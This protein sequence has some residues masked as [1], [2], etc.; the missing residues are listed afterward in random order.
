MYILLGHQ[1]VNRLSFNL[2]EKT[3]ALADA[4]SKYD[5][6]LQEK[7]QSNSLCG[8]MV[9]DPP[10]LK[11][12]GLLEKNEAMAG[13]I[14]SLKES[15]QSQED[16]LTKNSEALDKKPIYVLGCFFNLKVLSNCNKH[17][18]ILSNAV[19]AFFVVVCIEGEKNN[20]QKTDIFF[21][22]K[23]WNTVEFEGVDVILK[24]LEELVKM[25]QMESDKT[26]TTPPPTIDDENSPQLENKVSI[27]EKKHNL[28]PF[29]P[30]TVCYLVMLQ[31]FKS[32][33]N[34]IHFFCGCMKEN[35]QIEELSNEETQTNNQI[36]TEEHNQAVK[37]HY[38]NETK[39]VIQLNYKTDDIIA[40][41]VK[42]ETFEEPLT[43]SKEE[44]RP[45]HKCDPVMHELIAFPSPL[46]PAHSTE[47]NKSE[48]PNVE[49][50]ILPPESAY[51]PE[52]ETLPKKRSLS[53][54]ETTEI[55][56]P[57]PHSENDHSTPHSKRRK[58]L[59]SD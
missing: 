45:V 44:T 35:E 10:F 37:N 20:T 47:E 17:K 59:S 56:T 4:S 27:E 2:N 13:Q 36:E 7:G 9:L 18:A 50:N 16:Q 14:Q 33:L 54:L 12:K 39:I 42:I 25:E 23:K 34:L 24:D 5:A 1:E 41:E 22:W 29:L 48:T 30:F 40:S 58:T 6:L 32:T 28:L 11:M 51:S 8:Q 21:K 31:G 19:S 52:L 49:Q 53:M 46:R 38:S 55:H 57:S 3:L 26:E 43:F 15:I